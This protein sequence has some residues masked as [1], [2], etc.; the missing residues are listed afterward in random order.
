M[1]QFPVV[2][3][4]RTRAGH[5]CRPSPMPGRRRCRNHGGIIPLHH[6]AETKRKISAGVKRAWAARRIAMALAA[7][8]SS[9]DATAVD[10]TRS[11][12]IYCVDAVIVHT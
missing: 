11:R 10:A 1:Y 6:T 2:C 9:V 12:G 4:A 8:A 7:W 5:P 3:G